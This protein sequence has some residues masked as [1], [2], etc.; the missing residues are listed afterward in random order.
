MR[1][2][3]YCWR[4]IKAGSEE[5]RFLLAFVAG[6]N[7]ERALRHGEWWWWG[8]AALFVGLTVLGLRENFRAARMKQ[9]SAIGNK[10]RGNSS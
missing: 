4:A 10:K 9:L 1:F 3:G 2:W 8:A 7:T 5:T 6:M